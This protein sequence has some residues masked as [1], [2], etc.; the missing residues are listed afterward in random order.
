MVEDLT[1]DHSYEGGQLP[2]YF[3]MTIWYAVS[4]IAILSFFKRALTRL[5]YDRLLEGSLHYSF[6]KLFCEEIAKYQ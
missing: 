5:E 1:F 4:L 6:I 3:L 2:R